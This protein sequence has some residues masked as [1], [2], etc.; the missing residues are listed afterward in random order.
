M[1]K[2]PVLKSLRTKTFMKS[3]LYVFVLVCLFSC[4]KE[5][6]I[7]E[8]QISGIVSS[9]NQNPIDGVKIFL[10]ETCIMCTGSLPIETTYT[11]KSGSFNFVFKPKEDHSYH[12]RFEKKDYTIKTYHPIDLKK[13]SQN[14]NIIMDTVIAK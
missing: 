4:S 14:F 13:E 3:I 6:S 12:I 10:N 2:K 1:K 9:T 11:N 5:K 8:I 7:D